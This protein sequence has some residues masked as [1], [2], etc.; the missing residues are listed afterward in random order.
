[1]VVDSAICLVKEDGEW[2]VFDG[3]RNTRACEKKFDN[4]ALAAM[5][6]FSRLAPSESEKLYSQY[7]RRLVGFGQPQREKIA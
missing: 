3:C 5:E 6:M 1:M 7:L 2:V 4:P